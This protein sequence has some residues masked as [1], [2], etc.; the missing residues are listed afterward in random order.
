M[1]Q[2]HIKYF[3][4]HKHDGIKL[5]LIT[6][7]EMIQLSLSNKHTYYSLKAIIWVQLIRVKL[8]LVLVIDS[9]FIVYPVHF[10][11]LNYIFVSLL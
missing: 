6:N 2:V 3:H 1:I 9:L 4:F 8:E 11:L 7:L 10:L 5:S